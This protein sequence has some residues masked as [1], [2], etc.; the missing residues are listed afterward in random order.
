MEPC[1]FEGVHAETAGTRLPQIGVFSRRNAARQTLESLLIGKRIFSRDFL[2]T[3]MVAV[4]SF[5][6]IS[7]SRTGRGPAV[8]AVFVAAV[9]V[10]AFGGDVLLSDLRSVAWAQA[11][12]LPHHS[13]PM[14][15]ADRGPLP[16]IAPPA[17]IVPSGQ[18][19]LACPGDEC[20]SLSSQAIS[21]TLPG[22][23]LATRPAATAPP[24]SCD[25]AAAGAVTRSGTYVPRHAEIALTRRQGTY[26]VRGVVNECLTFDFHLDSGAADV[27]LPRAQFEQLRAARALSP[28]EI[29]G[30]DTYVMADGRTATQ[31]LFL[32]KTLQIG[33]MI[34]R[35]VR[36]AVM[37]GDAPA[38][39]GMSFLGRFA[40][41]S[42]NNHRE[43]L[44]LYTGSRPADRL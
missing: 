31:E 1:G 18:P 23:G 6:G 42:I 4:F 21:S 40:V 20:A 24:A 44:S 34:V 36:A 38:L 27:T 29:I 35:D 32:I 8:A 2:V 14:L 37:P 12:L 7:S 16:I 13:L 33:P 39:L 22:T 5:F 19:E 15:P 41:W 30:S 9:F 28:A 17:S 26:L 11:P 10:A 43:V 25:K 3:D